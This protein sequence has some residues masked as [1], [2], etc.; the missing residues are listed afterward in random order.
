M[1]AGAGIGVGATA[2]D[3]EESRTA[4]TGSTNETAVSLAQESGPQ[5]DF[6]VVRP[7]N[8]ILVSG[9]SVNETSTQGFITHE[10]NGE[11]EYLIVGSS[12]GNER[13]EVGG[14]LVEVD[15]NTDDTTYI[16][17]VDG[18]PDLETTDGDQI[19]VD[20]DD[21]GKLKTASGDDIVVNT[22][23]GNEV[24][25]YDQYDQPILEIEITKVNDPAEGENL[26]VNTS[27]TNH[28]YDNYAGDRTV[29]WNGESKTAPVNVNPE[30]QVNESFVFETEDGD[31][32]AGQ[33]EFDVGEQSVT[34]DVDI[35]EAEIL[36][37][38]FG[39][40]TAVAGD[41]ILIGAEFERIGDVP[42]EDMT[43]EFTVGNETVETD[44]LEIDPGDTEDG[45]ISYE[46]SSSDVP[47]LD[48]GVEIPELGLSNETTATV[49]S[50]DDHEENMNVEIPPDEL[51]IGNFSEEL[52]VTG[53]FEYNGEE[54]PNGETDVP[55]EF[56]VNG[57][58][59]EERDVTIDESPFEETFTWEFN[60]STMPIENVSLR[61]PSGEN[62]T[63][64]DRDLDIEF[65]EFNETFSSNEPLEAT[66]RV[67]NNGEVPELQNLSVGV[68]DADN[69]ASNV[70]QT[71]EFLLN[72]SESIEETFS[73]DLTANASSG[74][75][76]VANT[77]T[78]SENVTA[79][80]SVFEASDLE[81]D[82]ASNP[83][84]NLT[85]SGNITNI[86]DLV[87]TQTVQ[88]V[89]DGETVFEEELT[90]ESSESETVLA[91]IE[92]PEES[93]EY[94]YGITTNN[95]S[96][97]AS[98]AVERS[99]TIEGM[100]DQGLLDRIT[101]LHLGVL[102]LGLLALVGILL[103]YQNNPGA[104]RSRAAA[105]TAGAQGA[106]QRVF[107]GGDTI[108]VENGLSRDATV[109]LRVRDS[110]EVVFLEDLTL[111]DGEQREFK[112][113]PDSDEFEVGAGVDDIDSHAQVFQ[114]KPNGVGVRLE[115]DGI[116]ITEQ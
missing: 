47:E 108:V 91:D 81:L 36:I 110:N 35:E 1:G 29:S 27:I 14:Q 43:V 55:T 109:R 61:T 53:E 105:L 79:N 85:M 70:T 113:L 26:V 112:C 102:V 3:T 41:D 4:F 10:I 68:E 116:R 77:T 44:S 107:G 42:V 100:A 115:P 80:R 89:L 74:I 21:G 50:K 72:E 88:F 25:T 60:E 56:L 67:E 76:L 5:D 22:G 114:T 18:S 83:R 95:E 12:F 94:T 6:V 45:E 30:S 75:E 49:V 103:A 97:N 104:F 52:E 111:A 66:V 87:D 32:S 65:E 46:T 64:F 11:D 48:V 63:E 78:V 98:S 69:V 82:G 37:S 86:G 23:D 38:D 59:V 17:R 84:S 15:D 2:D 28:G 62:V 33:V 13:L 92:P 101:P 8:N 57:T 106:V 31:S 16:Q 93:G 99:A 40:T 90:L 96:L 7:G 9:E 19:E 54:I 71:R 24:L 51:E 58:V 34:Q 73:F 39:T 20:P